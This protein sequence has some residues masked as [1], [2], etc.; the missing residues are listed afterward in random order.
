MSPSTFKVI[1]ISG[2]GHSG[3]TLLD[4]ILGS[5]KR[6]F[7]AGELT[8][9]TRDSIFQEYCSCHSK[10]K[11]CDF[12]SKVIKRW[13]D[14]S[15]ISLEDYKKLRHKYERNKTT[16]RVLLNSLFPS[17]EFKVYCKSTYQLFK[18]IHEQSGK[19][20]IIDSS[21]SP[22]RI[23]ILKKHM[24]LKVIHLCRNAKGVLNSSKKV[25]KKDIKAGIEEDNFARRTSKTLIEWCF[26]NFITELFCL[27]VD[28]HKVKYNSYVKNPKILNQ[29]SK[30]LN[31]NNFSGLSPAHMIAGNKIRLQK[32][33]DIQPNVGS[34]FKNI[35]QK[36]KRV[37]SI[38][39]FLFPYW[40]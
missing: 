4:I 25:H 23:L 13:Q 16:I 7:S 38:F 28:S 10:I 31:L 30:K 39:E 27:S 35:N 6:A 1:Y 40:C 5:S 34:D 21:K 33:L 17:N 22:Q 19:S 26:V 14:I 3:S 29:I 37:A 11:D 15:D 24:D 32:A 8:F 12:W 18:I 20:I 36:Q 9:V 2:N